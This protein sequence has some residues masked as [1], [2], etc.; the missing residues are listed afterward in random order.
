MPRRK[1]P[2]DTLGIGAVVRMTLSDTPLNDLER[3]LTA[4]LL[5]TCNPPEPFGNLEASAEICARVDA[6]LR[7]KGIL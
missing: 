6:Q 4:R 3:V 5:R 1:G 7:R 2:K